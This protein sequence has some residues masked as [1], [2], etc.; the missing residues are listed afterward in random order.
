M[1]VAQFRHLDGLSEVEKE[2]QLM[3]TFIAEIFVAF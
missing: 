2:G 1:I 3:D